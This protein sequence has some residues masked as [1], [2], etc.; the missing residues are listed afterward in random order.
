[1]ISD[2]PATAR[3]RFDHEREIVEII[4]SGAL[5]AEAVM[6]M[7][8]QLAAHPE[9]KPHYNRLVTYT[10]ELAPGHVDFEALQAFKRVQDRW[11]AEHIPGEFIH[12]ANVYTLDAMAAL[13]R[14]WEVLTEKGPY[15]QVRGFR[16]REEAVAW[17]ESVKGIA[18]PV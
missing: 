14:V 4:W 6:R 12:A 10:S 11:H 7:L 13:V 18:R 2:T 17:L 1:M 16:T 3:F 15:F 5:S 8:D 9:W